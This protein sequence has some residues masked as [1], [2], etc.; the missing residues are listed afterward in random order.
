LAPIAADRVGEGRL[1]MKFAAA[2]SSH[3]DTARRGCV[4]GCAA[5]GLFP[6]GIAGVWESSPGARK[7][8]ECPRIQKTSQMPVEGESPC[9][10]ATG[11]SYTNSPPRA[12]RVAPRRDF[13]N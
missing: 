11:S 5:A 2:V 7:L 1:I 4:F 6:L 13:L 8:R 12:T 3:R 10:F 9:A